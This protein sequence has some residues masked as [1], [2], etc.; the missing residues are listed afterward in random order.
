MKKIYTLITKNS[1][2]QNIFGWIS[3]YIIFAVVS[4][5]NQMQNQ[6]EW[7]V[8]FIKGLVWPVQLIEFIIGTN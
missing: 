5:I 4:T 1:V 8:A 3:L 7:L 2:L 6:T